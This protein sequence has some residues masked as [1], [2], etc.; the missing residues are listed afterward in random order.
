VELTAAGEEVIL[1]VF[2]GGPGIS[3]AD[4][5]QAQEPFVRLGAP[6]LADGH[7]GLG[8]AIVALVAA[9][10]GGRMVLQPFDGERSGVGLAW[11][12]RHRA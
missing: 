11:P 7:C 10:L 12:R 4:F 6:S 8:L 9:Q 3:L 2:D 5:E 1:V